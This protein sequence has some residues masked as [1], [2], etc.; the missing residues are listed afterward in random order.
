VYDAL[1]PNLA[2]LSLYGGLMWNVKSPSDYQGPFYCSSLTTSSLNVTRW[3]FPV[4]ANVQMC[5]SEKEDHSPGAYGFTVNLLGKTSARI[6]SSIVRYSPPTDLGGVN[7]PGVAPTY[8][9]VSNL[10][11]SML[12]Q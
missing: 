11:R 1:D 3:G 2:S 10:A 7:I 12:G 4:A 6:T 9:S 8:Q 5:S